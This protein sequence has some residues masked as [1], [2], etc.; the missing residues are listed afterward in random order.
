MVDMDAPLDFETEDPLLSCPVIPQKRKKVMDLDDLVADFYREKN[1][2]MERES[3]RAKVRKK[4]DADDDDCSKE[5]LLSRQIDECHNQMKKIG[6]EEEVSSASIQVFGN[7]K[8]APP[9]AFPEL[10]SCSILQSIESDKFKSLLEVNGETGEILLQGLL[11]NEWLSKLVSLHGHVE[12]SIAKWVFHLMLY[13]PNDELRAAACSFWCTIL[14]PENEGHKLPTE[15]VPNHS[16][17]RK[18]LETYGFLFSI[19]SPAESVN[20]NS[21]DRG[22][23]KNISVWIKFIAAYCHARSKQ[24]TFS[25]SE[26]EEFIEIII[27]LYLDTQLQGLLIQLYEC[28]QSVISCFTDEEWSTSCV[29]IAKSL[30]CRLPRDLSCLRAVE[31][32]SEISTRSNH[33]RNVVSYHVLLVCLDNKAPNEDEVLRSLISIDVKD[34]NCDLFKVYICLV[35]TENWL[36]SNPI[37][38]ERPII[39]EMWGVYLR[40]CSSHITST[41]LRPYASKIRT[42][43]SYCLHES[44]R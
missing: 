6:D 24:P 22:P 44:R 7:R 2:V 12:K 9:A 23:P 4:Y 33:L 43:A 18:A 26:A 30:A 5:A 20:K 39:F 10:R 25:A 29:N 35:L 14:S 42:R 31:C 40:Q 38:K 11:L 21:G 1:K 36:L 32:I 17:L 15:W 27:F 37:L 19:S 3:K 28:L 13:S 41:D 16:E 34:K 8:P